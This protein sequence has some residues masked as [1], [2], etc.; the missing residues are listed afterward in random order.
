MISI[1]LKGQAVLSF[2]FQSSLTLN[3]ILV[4]V[5]ADYDVPSFSNL[6]RSI[7]LSNT[8]T[9]NLHAFVSKYPGNLTDQ[10]NEKMTE[11]D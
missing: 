6:I 7:F 1:L 5:R 4:N 10:T 11:K 3:G 9:V 8:E 2:S